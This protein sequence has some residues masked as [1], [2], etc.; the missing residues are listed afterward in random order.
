MGH[1]LP[2]RQGLLSDLKQA[3][4][5]RY[6]RG[7]SSLAPLDI[8]S[9]RSNISP[10]DGI[11]DSRSSLLL[12]ERLDLRSLNGTTQ[13]TANAH[14]TLDYDAR[15]RLFQR[16]SSF[17][18]GQQDT[19][20]C[21]Q[22]C[23]HQLSHFRTDLTAIRSGMILQAI[24]MYEEST[25]H[26]VA[27]SSHAPAVCSCCATKA[28]TYQVILYRQSPRLIGPFKFECTGASHS[29][30]HSPIGLFNNATNYDRTIL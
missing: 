16:S 27:G 30:W 25:R 2:G 10:T 6:Q 4:V 29:I 5:L 24:R 7:R 18:S 8:R 1:T 9:L 21:L 19:L 22:V 11:V 14:I 3:R 26:E 20:D 23:Y 15:V 28:W 12:D 13:V 17:S